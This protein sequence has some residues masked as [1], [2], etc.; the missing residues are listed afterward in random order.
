VVHEEFFICTNSL[1]RKDG[2]A[3]V[4]PKNIKLGQPTDCPKGSFAFDAAFQQP[5]WFSSPQA[6]LHLSW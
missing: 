6:L 1:T 5:E 4:C 3:D 2:P